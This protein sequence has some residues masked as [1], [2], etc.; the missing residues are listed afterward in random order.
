[1]RLHDRYFLREIA[2]PLA[3]GIAAF[4]MMQTLQLLYG[5]MDLLVQRRVPLATLG[6]YLLYKLPWMIQWSIPVSVLVGSSLALSRLSHD[7]ELTAMRIAGLPLWRFLVALGG[8]GLAFSVLSG[9]MAENMVPP[10]DHHAEAIFRKMMFESEVASLQPDSLF[11]SKN[12]IYYFHSSYSLGPSRTAIQC[13]VVYPLPGTSPTEPTGA[14]PTHGSFWTAQ[15]AVVAGQVWLLHNV[16]E[17]QVGTDGEVIRDVDKGDV[18]ID[19]KRD[20]KF[21]LSNQET[22][23]EMT[24]KEL[25]ARIQADE[26]IRL[27]KAVIL[28]LR[29]ERAFRGALPY[30]C[31][32]F[33]LLSAP[34]TLRFGQGG[35]L[36]GMLVAFGV[37]FFY[38]DVMVIA[39]KLGTSGAIPAEVAAWF[40]NVLFASLGAYLVVIEG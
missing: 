17:H 40:P 9:W 34:L 32:V 31:L 12:A 39:Q 22:P 19:L 10:T 4:V 36:L 16:I 8:V 23:Q 38:Y 33:V 5:V 11:R 24:S 13:V 26:Q 25:T 21:F 27:P 2:G 37:L 1:M 29:Y 14:G 20:I 3:I 15:Q 30:A 7:S 28:P 35:S 18:K 6:Q